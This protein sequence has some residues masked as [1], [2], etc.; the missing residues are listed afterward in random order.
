MPWGPISFH[1]AQTVINMDLPMLRDRN[2][3]VD[4]TT[5]IH[6]LG[7]ATRSETAHG[8]CINVVGGEEETRTGSQGALLL[9]QLKQKSTAGNPDA[10]STLV[11]FGP[12]YDVQVLPL[13]TFSVS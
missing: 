3:Q 12:Q 13:R 8:L 10:N 6:R 7:R 2:G 1:A 11:A 4:E 5:Y 9:A